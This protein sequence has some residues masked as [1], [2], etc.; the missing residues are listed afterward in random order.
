LRKLSGYRIVPHR[1]RHRLRAVA[2]LPLTSAGLCV[3]GHVLWLSSP[4]F[5]PD[6]R[7]LELRGVLL[8]TQAPPSF[9]GAR[10]SAT[11]S[12]GARLSSLAPYAAGTRCGTLALGE[13]IR[14]RMSSSL[15]RHRRHRRTRSPSPALRDGPR[16][17]CPQAHL[18]SSSLSSSQV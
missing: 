11:P 7:A 6:L 16:S 17:I 12:A 5:L 10:S 3:S 2:L 8:L 18:R 1:R 13:D 9:V 14:R 4:L 15:E